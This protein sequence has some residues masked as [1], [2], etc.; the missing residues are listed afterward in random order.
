MRVLQQNVLRLQVAVDHSSVPKGDQGRQDLGDQ[1]PDQVQRQ[2]VKVVHFQQLVQIVV[3]ELEGY[4][5]VVPKFTKVQHAHDVVL[6][7]Q[8]VLRVQVL[9]DGDLHPGLVEV[10]RLVLDDLQGY[11]LAGV[12][13]GAPRH[14]AEGAVAQDALHAKPPRV[15]ADLVAQI[16]NQVRVLV[17]VALVGDPH[18]GLRQRK[19]ALLV[20]RLHTFHQTRPALWRCV[21]ACVC[22]E[23]V[24]GVIASFVYS[25]VVRTSLSRC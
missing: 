16:Q 17:V 1:G 23:G 8:V 11:V 21:C 14:L 19:P 10:S 9:Q 25:Q 4:A 6:G 18:G 22:V 13:A 15:H 2:A 7:L 12:E 20:L 24:W 5:Q 3:Q